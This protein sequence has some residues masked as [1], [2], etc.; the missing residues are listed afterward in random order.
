MNDPS[1]PSSTPPATPAFPSAALVEGAFPLLPPP[2]AFPTA[3]PPLD[4]G[5]TPAPAAYPYPGQAY[6]APTQDALVAQTSGLAIASLVCSLAALSAVILTV[7]IILCIPGVILGHIAL[8]RIGHSHGQL[9]GKGLAI[10]G[11]VVG[12]IIFALLLLGI[13]AIVLLVTPVGV[14]YG[15]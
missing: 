8:W 4:S 11:L 5:Y 1:L 6:L 3:P 13:V 14:H 7:T 9:K 10:A 12:Y 2:P 15:L